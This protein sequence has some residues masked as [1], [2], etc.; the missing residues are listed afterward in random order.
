MC[1]SCARRTAKQIS[2]SAIRRPTAGNQPRRVLREI[3]SVESLSADLILSVSLVCSL[4][5]IAL[6]KTL[7][8]WINQ[9]FLLFISYHNILIKLMHCP[10]SISSLN[11]TN[12]VLFADFFIIKNTYAV[13]GI[14]SLCLRFYYLIQLLSMNYCY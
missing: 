6:N 11:P 5:P 3:W 14:V 8:L 7:D 13:S 9:C 2:G 1:R 12:Y 4:L 10:I